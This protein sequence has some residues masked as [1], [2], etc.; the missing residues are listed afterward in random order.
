MQIAHSGEQISA[1]RVL[2]R[3]TG[4]LRRREGWS[5]PESRPSPFKCTLA[6]SLAACSY[7]P[8]RERCSPFSLFL[9]PTP[10]GVR[11]QETHRPP[12]LLTPDLP[13]CSPPGIF[14]PPN[15]AAI[16]APGRF[17]KKDPGNSTAQVSL[18]QNKPQVCKRI[19]LPAVG[20][21]AVLAAP[22]AATT[23]CVSLL[24]LNKR[25]GTPLLGQ[26]IDA[27]IRV[28]APRS[29]GYGVSGPETL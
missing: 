20:A 13:S 2:C 3:G 8:A 24:R 18:T 22:E 11:S 16:K 29:I 15:S 27:R 12:L 9:G 14:K 23:Q 10:R 4:W 21:G 17:W 19:G 28:I 7:T 26:W 5:R 25:P 6:R 1:A